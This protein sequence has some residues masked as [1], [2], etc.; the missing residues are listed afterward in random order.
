MNGGLD[1]TPQQPPRA[2]E[3]TK[4][5]GEF[6]R[7]RS[8]TATSQPAFGAVVEFGPFRLRPAERVLEKDGVPI[9]IGSRALDILTILVEHAPQVV[10]K[11]DLIAR[12]WG[13]LVVDEGSL[14]FHIAALRK[15]LGDGE[16]G[17]RYIASVQGR[18]YAF[19]APV[20]AKSTR[21]ESASPSPTAVR[22]PSRSMRVLGRDGV[23]RDLTRELRERRFV[24]VIGPGGIGKT[25]VALAVAHEV[26]SEFAGDVHFLDL[27][28]IK[29]QQLVAGALASQLGLSVVS[30]NSI[31]TILALLNERRVLLLLDSC[32]HLIEPVAALVE[33]LFRGAPQVHLLA[34][35]RE[36]LRVEGEWVHHLSPLECPPREAVSLTATQ[37]LGFPAVQLF[38]EQVEAS[39]YPLELSDADAPIV[40][41]L[42]RRLD[43][44][45]LALELAARCVG[46]Y[47]IKG[48]ASLLDHQFSLLH[49]RRTATPRHQ[50]LTATLDW[51]HGLLSDTERLVLRRLAIFVGAFSLEAAVTVVA[52][53]LE[54]AQA[55]EALARLVE[56]SLVSLDVSAAARYRLLD[57]T[58]AYA[59]EKLAHSGEQ[60]IIARRHVEY[61]SSG[62]ERFQATAWK[63]LSAEGIDFFVSQ[64]GDV[65]AALDWSFGADG[66][67]GLGVRLAAAAAPFFFQ[68]SLSSE[69]VTWS[70]RALSRLDPGSATPLAL[71][72][73]TC[74][75]M[76]LMLMA[77]SPAAH[78]ALVRALQLAQT[79]EDAV[80]Q[81][82]LLIQ[83]Y[84][85][86][87]R[88]GE[89]RELRDLA[90]R[91][92]ALA[93]QVDDPL[94]NAI[95][96][97]T[98]A[99]TCHHLGEHV[100]ALGHAKIARSYPAHSS[101]LNANAFNHAP[102]VVPLSIQARSLWM[103]GYPDQAVEASREAIKEAER[104][105]HR[106]T[107]IFTLMW[108]T[109]VLLYVGDW[110]TTEDW[111][112][113]II[114]EATT[115]A[116]TQ[117]HSV[118]IGYQGILA[119]RLGEP[120]RGTELLQT[121][122]ARLH[123]DGYGGYRRIFAG[124]LAEGLVKAGER[125]LAHKVISE[126]VNREQECGPSCHMPELLRV[127]G[128]VLVS[129]AQSEAEQCLLDSLRLAG[130][131]R[132]LSFELRTGMSL[133]RLWAAT[134]RRDNALDL[135]GSIYSRFSE[136]FQ[137]LDL[138]SAATLR[139]EL[140]SPTIRGG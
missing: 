119:V 132:A 56:K 43:G 46:V 79:L 87:L 70:E 58:R 1:K 108:N 4:L 98:S 53:D 59:L 31:P 66:D 101:Q 63:R 44:I 127:K 5:Q 106:T 40:A 61:F 2:A 47:G 18:G 100:E 110:Q 78:A 15:V 17:A 130:D 121:A 85:Y 68:R 24:S 75:A 35:S 103:L 88:R 34:T 83:I 29:D 49:G 120:L 52:H 90:S 112:R 22:L 27:A 41:G 38:V 9:K 125:A 89:W 60:K 82:L 23:V 64:V 95:V 123:V 135:L 117:C 138:V 131:Q 126:T 45:P 65:R 102:N 54:A 25:T 20:T 122:V 136:G 140:R 92:E 50:T 109:H 99:V 39:G 80:S 139:D 77:N 13:T 86:K 67:G 42:C 3:N 33:E 124:E 28:A 128:E 8:D 93:Q 104:I 7:L 118:A 19:A 32:E 96:R 107:T 6:R 73:Q 74:F 81:L 137:T 30:Q 26:L 14:R 76:A 91:C 84:R 71:Q 105:N 69:C 94:A 36:S 12:A 55:T 129:M 16:S 72:L 48:T 51:S 10:S 37:A 115:D 114:A 111:I 116:V 62:L 133:A 97:T 11:R 113:R 21:S 134:G 57:T